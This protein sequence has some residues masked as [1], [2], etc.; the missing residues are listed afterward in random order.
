M[1][2]GAIEALSRLGLPS[3]G[4]RPKAIEDVADEPLDLV[5]TVCDNAREA[6]PAFPGPVK[7][8]PVA[9]QHRSQHPRSTP[10]R[11]DHRNPS[12][13]RRTQ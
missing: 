2:D 7:K 11:L 8:R 6:C 12:D 13:L 10:P 4:L 5:V 3:A 9:G 1:A